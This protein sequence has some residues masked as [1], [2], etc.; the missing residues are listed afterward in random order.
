MFALEGSSPS[1]CIFSFVRMK[2]HHKALVL[3]A[4]ISLVLRALND[5]IDT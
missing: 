2:L 4:A 1:S 3:T 5:A